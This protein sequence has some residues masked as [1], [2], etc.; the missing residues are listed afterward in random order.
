MKG[1][2]GVGASPNATL[3][4]ASQGAI[5][6]GQM[7][8]M[9]GLTGVGAP[10]NT[11]LCCASKGAILSGQCRKSITSENPSFCTAI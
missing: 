8:K 3:C 7:P 4:G 9:R 2:Q 6:S 10:P 1:L 5:L 11:T